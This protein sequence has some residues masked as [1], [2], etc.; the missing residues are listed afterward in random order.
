VEDGSAVFSDCQ[1]DNDSRG[2]VPGSNIFE[3]GAFKWGGVVRAGC[4]NSWG[5]DL[6]QEKEPR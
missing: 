1:Q 4:A 5:E 6:A 2:R 3:A